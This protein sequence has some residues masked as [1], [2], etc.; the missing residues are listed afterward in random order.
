MTRLD[1]NPV[2]FD[3]QFIAQKPYTFL[4][5]FP[6][7]RWGCYFELQSFILDARNLTPRR[8]RD[9]AKREGD[10]V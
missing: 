8:S 1:R 2:S 10:A 3:T 6:L 7:D 9:N 4:I 5:R